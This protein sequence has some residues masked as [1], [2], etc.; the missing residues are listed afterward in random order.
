MKPVPICPSGFLTGDPTM[1]VDGDYH[2]SSFREG[3]HISLDELLRRT[4]R[5]GLDNALIWLTSPHVWVRLP[6]SQAQRR[7][8]RFLHP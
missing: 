6:Q 1:I 3:V 2:I 8:K 7:T 5:S 4:D